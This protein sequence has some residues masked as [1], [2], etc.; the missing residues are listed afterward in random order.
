MT[1]QISNKNNLL[2]SS[3]CSREN[4]AVK[5]DREWT[6]TVLSR[7]SQE[8]WYLSKDLKEMRERASGYLGKGI[9]G[10]GSNVS[11]CLEEG[12]QLL[13]VGNMERPVGLQRREQGGEWE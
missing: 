13:C 10:R 7:G 2:D 12:S 5:D 11:T 3:E 6:V 4:K 8:E 1:N 9:P